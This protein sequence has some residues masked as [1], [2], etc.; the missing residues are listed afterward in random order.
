MDAWIR[1]LQMAQGSLAAAQALAVQG[2]ARSAA[3]RAYYAAY[4]AVTA[5]LLYHG[6]TPP[7]DREAWSHEATPDLLWHLAPT[8]LKQDRRKDMAH[9]LADLYDL[10]LIADYVSIA[11]VEMPSLK[12]ALKDASFIVGIV[13][14]NSPWINPG[15]STVLHRCNVIPLQFNSSSRASPCGW[16]LL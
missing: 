3:S 1:W 6:M 11:E 13:G 5:L 14:D 9:R 16:Q 15:A 2:E 10:R 7:E 12:T 8:T 4:Q